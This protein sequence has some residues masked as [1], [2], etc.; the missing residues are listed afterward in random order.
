MLF[1]SEGPRRCCL[2]LY[3]LGYLHFWPHGQR[4]A[5]KEKCNDKPSMAL[6]SKDRALL[7]LPS[8]KLQRGARAGKPLELASAAAGA[9]CKGGTSC[10]RPGV[11]PGLAPM[12]VPSLAG[13]RNPLEEPHAGSKH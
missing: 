3:P 9:L 1:R 13:E 11:Y 4:E 10:S 5:P 7:L 8:G 2:A 6:G 12:L